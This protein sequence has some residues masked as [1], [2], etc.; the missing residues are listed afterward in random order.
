M[1]YEKCARFITNSHFPSL[2]QKSTLTEI[3]TLPAHKIFLNLLI[4][5]NHQLVKLLVKWHQ[6]V[7]SHFS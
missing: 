7:L 4:I 5:N 2:S 3:P 1:L 6:N